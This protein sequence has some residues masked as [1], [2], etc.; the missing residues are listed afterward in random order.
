MGLVEDLLEESERMSMFNGLGERLNMVSPERFIN[1][2]NELKDEGADWELNKEYGRGYM[3]VL[4]YQGHCF[5]AIT[6]EKLGEL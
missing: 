5:C 3:H 1:A 4:S 6:K 2:L